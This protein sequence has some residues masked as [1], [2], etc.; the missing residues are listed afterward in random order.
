M[1]NIKFFK[2]LKEYESF[3][4]GRV[5]KTFSVHPFYSG[6]V[7]FVIEHRAPLFYEQSDECEYA[8]FTQ[9]F[10]FE[11]LR[12]YESDFIRDM[13]FMH[14]FVHMVFDNPINVS[15]MT[16]EQFEEISNYNEYMASN[17]TEVMTYYRIP[18]LRE[19]S[20]P[21]PILYDVLKEKYP[22]GLS[23]EKLLELRKQIILEGEDAGLG[24]HPDSAKIF[25][26]L[27]KYRENNQVWCSLWYN[28]FPKLDAPYYK[29]RMTLPLLSYEQVLTRYVSNNSEEK[30]QR[31][32]LDNIRIALEALGE[33]DLPQSFEECEDAVK[34]LEGR[35]IMEDTARAFHAHYTGSK[36]K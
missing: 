1:K 7:S 19:K 23:I 24:D 30:Y 18:E 21:Y 29:K 22:G 35:I 4:Y 33:K 6:L 3:V 17:E 11:L 26:H 5:I 31:N 34:R 27:R 10:N 2:T 20:L 12:T 14:D 9:Y 25:A 8:H 13:F 36:S 32:V 16:F 28:S 15:R